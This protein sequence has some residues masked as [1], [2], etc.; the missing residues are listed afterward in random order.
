MPYSL[1]TV[2]H[3]W[4]LPL[5]ASIAFATAL[6]Q[7]FPEQSVSGHKDWIRGCTD[8][9][10]DLTTGGLVVYSIN[11]GSETVSV[12]RCL[13]ATVEV[14]PETHVS[15]GW[16][17]IPFLSPVDQWTAEK[18][19]EPGR[20]TEILI[21]TATKAI[22][23][24]GSQS[25]W[26]IAEIKDVSGDVLLITAAHLTGRSVYKLDPSSGSVEYLTNGSVDV[27]DEDI[28]IFEVRGRKHYFTGGGAFWITA[29]ID[30]DGNILDMP[31]R[32]GSCMSVDELS[33]RSS[34]DLNRVVRPE[35]CVA[36]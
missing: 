15:D 22:V 36:R 32:G 3:R 11:S 30:G 31:L 1:R 21:R 27:V 5:T 29:T 12:I 17:A 6:A 16:L 23:V 35:V 13:L 26:G 2:C 9:S 7:E 20:F 8:A 10:V 25:D 18:G 14:L 19:G 34:L 33:E 24:S 4:V 28:P